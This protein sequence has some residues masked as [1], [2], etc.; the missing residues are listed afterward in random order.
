MDLPCCSRRRY[1]LL[2]LR[3]CL[4]GKGRLTNTDIYLSSS[5]R[6]KMCCPV[7]LA[8]ALVSY[9]CAHAWLARGHRIFRWRYDYYFPSP[10]LPSSDSMKGFF[11][12]GLNLPPAKF[13]VL[14]TLPASAKVRFFSS[15]LGS[16]IRLSND[17]VTRRTG[18]DSTSSW[19]WCWCWCWC[20][21]RQV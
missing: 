8:D 18:G 15:S 4:V 7:A 14:S 9:S 12:R 16:G 10:S 2:S 3:L 6:Q 11:A 13:S 1:R 21:E 17:L 5:T 19:C 20:F